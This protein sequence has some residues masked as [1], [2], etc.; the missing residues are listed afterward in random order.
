M[1]SATLSPEIAEVLK[2]HSELAQEVLEALSL[3]DYPTDFTPER[4][5]LRFDEI[6]FLVW[7]NGEVISV[8]ETDPDYKPEIVEID[9]DDSLAFVLVGDV[10]ALDRIH[11]IH[12]PSELYSYVPQH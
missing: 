7:E 12:L 3:P 11:T 10:V 8:L 2:D 5:A 6:A 9:L 4:F 1:S